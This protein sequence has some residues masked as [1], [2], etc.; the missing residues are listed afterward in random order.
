MT[1]DLDAVM[2]VMNAAFDPTFGEAWTR[3]QV[4]DTL[5]L[6]GTACMLADSAGEEPAPGETVAG[7]ALT[8]CVVDEEELLLLAVEP[9]WRGRG[10]GRRLLQRVVADA[11]ARRIARLFL[12]MRDGNDAA[13][14]Y[15]AAG[16][17]Q[18]GRRPG[19]YRRGSGGPFDAITCAMS[20]QMVDP[21]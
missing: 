3:R 4:E 14:L 12:E 16:F 8:R 13:R 18:V 2:A 5:L 6:P 1:D 9:R 7:F 11:Q 20:I 19:Y 10:V 21:S 17:A 15:A